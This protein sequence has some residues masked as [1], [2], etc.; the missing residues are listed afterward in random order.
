MTDQ[1]YTDALARVRKQFGEDYRLSLQEV[2]CDGLT[3]YAV[4]VPPHAQ[5]ITGHGKRL[6]DAIGMAIDKVHAN[7][8]P[9]PRMERTSSIG[10]ACN[11]YH[12]DTPTEY[13]HDE[14]VMFCESRGLNPQQQIMQ[15][16]NKSGHYPNNIVRSM[17]ACGLATITIM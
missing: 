14:F 5:G 13:T 4:I 12:S 7:K 3:F 8:E 11:I 16:P 1:D 10:F 15:T 6:Q 2:R 17:Q 9:L